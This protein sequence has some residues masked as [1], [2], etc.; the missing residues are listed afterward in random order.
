MTGVMGTDLRGRSGKRHTCPWC[1]KHKKYKLHLHI[2]CYLTGFFFYWFKY[3]FNID[4]LYEIENVFLAFLYFITLQS[5]V[6]DYT[7]IKLF[8]DILSLLILIW[9][10]STWCM[11]NMKL[12]KINPRA[13]WHWP[14]RTKRCSYDR[15]EASL[16][17]HLAYHISCKSERPN[18]RASC[19]STSRSIEKPKAAV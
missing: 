9:R 11:K 7:L 4:L 2:Y 10:R 19:W 14:P 17:R 18:V 1:W 15:G 16:R 8:N 3:W 6:I 5:Q 12:F 13:W